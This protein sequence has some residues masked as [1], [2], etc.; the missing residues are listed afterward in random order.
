M[1]YFIH[2]SNHFTPHGRCELNKLTSLPMWFH[3]SVGRAS[4]RYRGGHR[5]ES[6]WSS[7]FFQASSLQLS[8]M[9]ILHFHT[10]IAHI[11]ENPIPTAS[12]PGAFYVVSALPHRLQE[13]ETKKSIKANCKQTGV[14]VIQATAVLSRLT[15]LKVDLLSIHLSNNSAQAPLTLR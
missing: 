13:V 12:P 2:T 8:A 14:G 3:S 5:F 4:Y 7:D 9:I 1:N 6:R 11:R 15:D 10:Y